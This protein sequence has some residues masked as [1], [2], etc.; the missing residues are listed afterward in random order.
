MLQPGD[1]APSFTLADDRGGAVSL[2]HFRGRTVV[3]YFYPRDATP[4][5]TVEACEFRDAW[6][7]LQTRGVV[8]L[9]VSPDGAKSHARFRQRHKLPFPLLTDEDHR[10]A[11]KYGAWGAK[12]LFGLRFQGILR[13]TFVI[14][15]NGIVQQVF[16]QVKSRGHA[17]RILASLDSMP[18]P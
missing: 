12:S 6:D 16:E 13:T 17:A 7:E 18:P 11:S 15:G 10:V 5:C 2:E 4:S 1:V 9:G 8:V 3:L 14:D